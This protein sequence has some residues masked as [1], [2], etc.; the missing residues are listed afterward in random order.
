MARDIFTAT[1]CDD[2]TAADDAERYQ[3]AARLAGLEHVQTFAQ[4]WSAKPGS[5]SGAL[6]DQYL[7]NYLRVR[8]ELSEVERL[9]EIERSGVDFS[10]H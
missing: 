3:V 5:D 2:S 10:E 6:N 4:I 7:Q 9:L 8:L 1:V